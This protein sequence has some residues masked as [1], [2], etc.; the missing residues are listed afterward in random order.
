MWEKVQEEAWR[1]TM[2]GRVGE[3]EEQEGDVQMSGD[4]G[5]EKK[6]E[7]EDTRLLRGL[8]TLLLETEMLEGKLRCGSCGHEYGVKEGVGNFLLPAHLV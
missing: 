4:E 3:L 5:E 8:H 7:D 2:L 6:V 1:E